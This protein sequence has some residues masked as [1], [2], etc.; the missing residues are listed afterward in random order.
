MEIPVE[1]QEG[2]RGILEYKIYGNTINVRLAPLGASDLDGRWLGT[3]ACKVCKDCEEANEE[4]ISIDV[5]NGRFEIALDMDSKGQ[6]LINERG[7]MMIRKKGRE[8]FS[9]FWDA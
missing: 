5:H 4:P 3:V 6:G 2:R 8:I 9:F 1:L 7:H